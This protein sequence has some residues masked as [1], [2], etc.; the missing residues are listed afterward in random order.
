MKV[1]FFFGYLARVLDS[2]VPYDF[3]CLF[4]VVLLFLG[5]RY[6]AKYQLPVR[7]VEETLSVALG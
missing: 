3:F 6:I 5:N 4:L 1:S 7:G 2:W